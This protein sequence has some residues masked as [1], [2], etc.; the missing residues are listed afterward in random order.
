M[1]TRV[2]ICIPNRCAFASNRPWLGPD[3]TLLAPHQLT[4]VNRRVRDHTITADGINANLADAY[5]VG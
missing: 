2:L 5:A 3:L 1:R 4:I